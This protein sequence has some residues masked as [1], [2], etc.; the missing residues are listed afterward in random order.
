M[1]AR[2]LALALAGGLLAAYLVR[3]PGSVASPSGPLPPAPLAAAASPAVEAPPSAAGA[4]RDPFRY[5]DA[6]RNPEPHPGLA[7]LPAVR[8]AVPAQRSTD[9]PHLVGFVHRG[10]R[11]HAA[12]SIAGEVVL[13]GEG[14]E[15]D[16][17]RVLSVD[18]DQ[19]VRL[20]QPGGQEIILSS[21]S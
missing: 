15:A 9:Q 12:L 21:P 13:L 4:L 19:G 7:L 8:A 18:E 16:G 1:K 6:P 11:L 20:R 14:D 5:D 3:E 10:G 2:W 17:Y